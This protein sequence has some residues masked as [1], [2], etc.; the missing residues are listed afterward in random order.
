VVDLLSGMIV[1]SGSSVPNMQYRL[2]V[3]SRQ[4]R[5]AIGAG[6]NPLEVS[7]LPPEF[8][9]EN[10]PVGRAE[11]AV[12]FLSMPDFHVGALEWSP[13]GRLFA[14][15]HTGP[16]TASLQ[17]WNRALETF[18]EVEQF[19]FA[20]DVIRVAP[21]GP[22]RVAVAVGPALRIYPL[23]ESGPPLAQQGKTVMTL[24][25]LGAAIVRLAWSPDGRR[26]AYG[27]NGGEV[28]VVDAAA[29][30]RGTTYARH[31]GEV[32]GLIWSADGRTLISAD[33]ECL[34]YSDVETGMILDEMRPGW[35]IEDLGLAPPSSSG[36]GPLL[37]LVGS[38][39]AGSGE[40]EREARFGIL[41]LGRSLTGPGERP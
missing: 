8:R 16:N 10:T 13:D 37:V 18:A 3:D 6:Y 41:N 2:A 29:A 9:P 38:A 23:P 32:V 11:E 5:M 31:A 22:P 4:R 14:G 24:P 27:T 1:Q 17:V 36:Q 19:R 30:G 15:C 33:P 35:A 21:A 7:S 28:T 20:V 39:I 12:R 25:V 40:A 26:I 34:R